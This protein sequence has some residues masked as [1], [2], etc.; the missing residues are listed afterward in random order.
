MKAENIV[1]TY[2]KAKYP[3]LN[4]V[5]F[6][7][8]PN[9]INVLV[10]PNGA[11]KTTLFDLMAGILRPQS[12]VAHFPSLEQIL[13][14]TQSVFFSPE[15]KGKDFCKFIRRI[16]SQP[17][18]SSCSDYIPIDRERE[19]L[20]LQRLWDIKIGK[21][22][23]GER[24]WL[25]TTMLAEQADRELYLFDEPTSG[26]DPTSRNQIFR[27]IEGLIERNKTVVLSTHQLNDLKHLDCHIIFLH[28]GKI[29]YEGDYG[30]WLELYD[31][32]DP[33]QAFDMIT[34]SI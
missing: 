20:L 11:G 6:E 29:R 9:K 26:V 3:V 5:N 30:A 4:G 23:V 33:D 7:L 19:R 13:Y 25:F 12:G 8:H 10:G 34:S 18:S 27:M 2:K 16:S 32:D 28:N 14:I 15:I 24:R 17:A 21:M 31:T 1:F 22:S